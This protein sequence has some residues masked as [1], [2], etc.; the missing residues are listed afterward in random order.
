MPTML[1]PDVEKLVGNVLRADSGVNAVVGTRVYPGRP[2]SPQWPFL[3]VGRY[4][5]SP[6]FLKPDEARIQLDGYGQSGDAAFAALNAAYNAVWNMTGPHTEG[7]VTGVSVESGPTWL[8][9]PK[10]G[11]PRWEMTV[12]VYAR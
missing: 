8:P 3:V 5:G 6:R 4:G 12:L 10:T 2:K 7:Y 9:D 1:L 11:E